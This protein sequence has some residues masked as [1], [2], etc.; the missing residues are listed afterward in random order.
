MDPAKRIL[1]EACVILM[2]RGYRPAAGDRADE[3]TR[4]LIEDMETIDRGHN[5]N[6]TLHLTERELTV[7]QLAAAGYTRNEIGELTGLSGD[8]VKGH[9]EQA[10]E[11]L[12]A[13]NTVNAVHIAH[14]QGL[15]EAA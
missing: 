2:R 10:R 3:V 1:A 7:L 14:Q 15:L 4:R 12:G 11:K 13:R 8:T 9:Q 5:Y 6:S